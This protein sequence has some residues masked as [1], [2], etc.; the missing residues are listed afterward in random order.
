MP[1]AENIGRAKNN[2]LKP[3]QI[4]IGFQKDFFGYFQV[5][6]G[7][8]VACW[9]AF[10]HRTACF[11]GSIIHPKGADMY[12]PFY[13]GE[14]DGFGHIQGPPEIYLESGVQGV[15]HPFSD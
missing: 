12:Q 11:L 5:G 10:L 4:L 1:Q 13:A 9:K 14:T 2:H 15:R 6:L 8:P 7:T 3:V